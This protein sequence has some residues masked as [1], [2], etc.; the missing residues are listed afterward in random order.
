MC[1]VAEKLEQKGIAKGRIEG[2]DRI[3]HLY[4]LLKS[5]GRTNDLLRAIDDSSY[6]AKLLK[7]MQK[8]L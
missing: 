7:Q 4:Q 5:E 6:R 8:R 3:N 2:E 1:E